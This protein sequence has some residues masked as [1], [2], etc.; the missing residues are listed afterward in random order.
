MSCEVMLMTESLNVITGSTSAIAS[1]SDNKILF[2]CFL[3][4]LYD[5]ELEA[6][7]SYESTRLLLSEAEAG[8]M[9]VD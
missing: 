4:S 6:C 5:H 2:F 7:S 1:I 3:K 8:A 9:Q